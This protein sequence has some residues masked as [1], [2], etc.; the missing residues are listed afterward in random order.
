[1]LFNS[2]NRIRSSRIERSISYITMLL[3]TYL[4][5]AEKQCIPIQLFV[6]E[7]L[8][9]QIMSTSGGRSVLTHI[10]K[11]RIS[12]LTYSWLRE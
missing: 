1:M 3:L 12:N 11:N 9:V 7:E 2:D 5:L 10:N 8:H 6:H 4:K